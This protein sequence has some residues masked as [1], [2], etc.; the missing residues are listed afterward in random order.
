MA[1]KSDFGSNLQ[2]F[3][4]EALREVIKTD[5]GPSCSFNGIDGHAL[6]NHHGGIH[7]QVNLFHHGTSNSGKTFRFFDKK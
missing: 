4:R 5:F 7:D 6:D 3:G 1:N 2:D